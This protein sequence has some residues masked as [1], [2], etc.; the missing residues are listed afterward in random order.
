MKVLKIIYTKIKILNQIGYGFLKR[1]AELNR[2]IFS[3]ED[4]QK[5]FIRKEYMNEEKANKILD[6]A[7]DVYSRVPKKYFKNNW[8]KLDNNIKMALVDMNY[9]GWFNSLAQTTDFID[10]ISKGN[11][12]EAINSIKNSNYYKQDKRR[13]NKNIELIRSAL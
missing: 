3:E 1:G 11:L 8:D 4:Y 10:N 13:A 7:I 12:E 9:Q 5:Y 6:K 2:E